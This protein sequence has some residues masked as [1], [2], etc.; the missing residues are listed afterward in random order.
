MPWKDPEKRLQYRKDYYQRPE[1]KQRIKDWQKKNPE[2]V[3]RYQYNLKLEVLTHYGSKPPKC[4][5]CGETEVRFLSI[6][7][8]NGDGHEHR[9]KIGGNGS[10]LYYWLKKN[11]YPEGFQVLCYDCNFSKGQSKVQFCPV[12]HP[13][14]YSRP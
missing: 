13:E 12:H 8:I 5:C 9:R 1:V 10:H 11:S 4:A 2:A 14:L 7:H 3:K 6:D